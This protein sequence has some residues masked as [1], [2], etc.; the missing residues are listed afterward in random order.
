M[1]L[2][3]HHEISDLS[4][5]GTGRVKSLVSDDEIGHLNILLYT[6]NGTLNDFFENW[7]SGMGWDL[8]GRV[9]VWLQLGTTRTVWSNDG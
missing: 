4:G 6:K 9:Q 7:R 1:E 3:D 5:N 8:G 2:N